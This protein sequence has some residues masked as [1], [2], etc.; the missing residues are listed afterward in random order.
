MEKPQEKRPR[1]LS[2][3]L[4]QL[5]GADVV[6]EKED[7]I[8][9]RDRAKLLAEAGG[10]K[11]SGADL[12]KAFENWRREKEVRRAY[13]EYANVIREQEKRDAIR[14]KWRGVYGTR[15]LRHA[16]FI[17][18]RD[19]LESPYQRW[20]YIKR[21]G[22]NIGDK[23]RPIDPREGDKAYTVKGIANDCCLIFEGMGSKR[24][25]RRYEKINE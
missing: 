5:A 8:A 9:I 23:V 11:L 18:R 4:D 25:P 21:K 20:L 6:L 15:V 10:R 14:G 7:K 17:N 3:Y 1:S 16:D 2:A 19:M 24:I 22:I 13:E 12:E